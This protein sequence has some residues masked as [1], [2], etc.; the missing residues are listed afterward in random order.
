M[1]VNAYVHLLLIK[2]KKGGWKLDV[3]TVKG[4]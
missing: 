2:K 4:G 1:I 3:I